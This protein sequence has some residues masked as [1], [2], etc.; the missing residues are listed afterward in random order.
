MTKKLKKIAF[1]LNAICRKDSVVKYHKVFLDHGSNF[2]HNVT[3]LLEKHNVDTRKT[4]KKIQT[5][6]HRFY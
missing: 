2:K 3:E 4:K 1:V 5:H 6:S